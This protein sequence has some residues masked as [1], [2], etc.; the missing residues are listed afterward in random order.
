MMALMIEAMIPPPSEIPI[1]GNSQP[2]I[3]APMM[4]TTMLPTSQSR[5]LS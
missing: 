5:N 2:A 4:P 3:T 1:C